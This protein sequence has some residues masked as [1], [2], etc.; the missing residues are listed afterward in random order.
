M[1][2]LSYLRLARSDETNG[3]RPPLET[4]LNDAGSVVTFPICGNEDVDLELGCVKRERLEAAVVLL[5]SVQPAVV[6]TARDALCG[7]REHAAVPLSELAEITD[8]DDLDRLRDVATVVAYNKELG[9][10]ADLAAAEISLT[11]VGVTKP[12]LCLLVEAARLLAKWTFTLTAVVVG[13]VALRTGLAW[14]RRRLQRQ[15]QEL[16]DMVDRIVDVVRRHAL[17]PGGADEAF[18]PENHVR[19]ELL[20]PA[21][22]SNR[23]QMALWQR[24]V[25]H[26]RDGEGRVREECVLVAGESHLVWRWMPGSAA[27]A[28]GGPG[29]RRIWLGQAFQTSSGVNTPVHTRTSCLKIRHMFDT[30]CETGTA[31]MQEVQDALLEKCGDDVAVLHIAVDDRST[32]GLVYVKCRSE[33]DAL[34]A[35]KRIQ[36]CWFDGR[37]VSVKFIRLTRY[38]ERYPDA[39]RAQTPLQPSNPLRRSVA[40]LQQPQPEDD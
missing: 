16:C 18:V 12:W 3:S 8:T 9:L 24:A 15:Q 30:S 17:S 4:A 7:R 35:F 25:Q 34:T 6:A 26:I 21:E 28:A 27:K 13:A 2:G 40:G 10:R 36:G 39:V 31:W 19:D 37:L 20:T 1:L 38:H 29:R 32:E 23:G 11:A 14:R 22:R 5:A 33:A